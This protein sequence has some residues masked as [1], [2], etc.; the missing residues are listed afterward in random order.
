MRSRHRA[1]AVEGVA[2]VGHP[3]AQR[4]VHG[5]L[6]R[7]AARRHRDHLGTQKLHAE[8]IGLLPLDVVVGNYSGI[9]I[10]LE[11]VVVVVVVV[12]LVERRRGDDEIEIGKEF[13][14]PCCGG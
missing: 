10:F 8:D 2:H 3:V 7:A 13:R 12:I 1:D 9:I 4:V 11:A 5:V 14:V 6:Q